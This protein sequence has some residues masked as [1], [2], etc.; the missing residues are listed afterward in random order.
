VS[1]NSDEVAAGILKAVFQLLMLAGIFYGIYS[2]PWLLLLLILIAWSAWG[3]LKR[4]PGL[5]SK[6]GLLAVWSSMVSWLA[7]GRAYYLGDPNWLRWCMPGFA[8][9]MVGG[10]AKAWVEES[11]LK[12]RGAT[13]DAL[14]HH[15]LEE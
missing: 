1:I 8:T 11:E 10:F 12:R 5:L 14:G 6:I 15:E 13:R 3:V 7:A 9:V 2:Y 4:Q